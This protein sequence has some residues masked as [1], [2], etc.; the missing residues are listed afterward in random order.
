MSN[1]GIFVHNLY[2]NKIFHFAATQPEV[3][4]PTKKRKQVSKEKVKQYK[5]N[6]GSNYEATWIG[7]ETRKLYTTGWKKWEKNIL[8]PEIILP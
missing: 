5:R 8:L 4:K 3:K 7:P 6:G 2:I 1:L